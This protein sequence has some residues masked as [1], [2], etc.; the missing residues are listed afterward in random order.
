MAQWRLQ[1]R[2][3]V[4]GACAACKRRLTP[5]HRSVDSQTSASR[6]LVCPLLAW[7]FLG[8]RLQTPADLSEAA[9][10][11]ISKPTFGSRGVEGAA[12]SPP[13]SHINWI[14]IPAFSSSS[15]AQTAEEPKK[16]PSGA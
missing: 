15:A 10:K 1:R 8:G 2:Q 16:K 9:I 11:K 4:S 3:Q 12:K 6:T 7:L 14:S 13:R 5:M